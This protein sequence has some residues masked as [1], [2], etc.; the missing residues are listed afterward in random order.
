VHSPL[1]RVL[2]LTLGGT[3]ASV[4]DAK[5][6]H[7]VPRLSPAELMASVPG[8]AEVADVRLESFRQYPSGDLSI[9]D[10]IELAQLVGRRAD[11]VDGFVIT[12]GTDTLE[13]TSY[14]L[15]LLLD[16]NGPPVVVTG[17][18]RNAG[19]PGADGPANILAAI[20]V[21]V[22]REARGLGPLVVFA[23]EIHLPRFVRK[24]H[25]SSVAAFSSPNAG[26]VGWVTE[27]RVRIP[28]LA[29]D[30]G[31]TLQPDAVRVPPPAVGIVK[32]GLGSGPLLPE[33]TAGFEGLVV[34]VF[35]GGHVPSSVVQ[36][37]AEVND[38]IPVVMATRT[39]AGELYRST[40]AFP[41]SEQDLLDRGM[42]SAG[43]LDGAKARL[44][45]VLLL[46][47]GAGRADI[48]ARFAAAP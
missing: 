18:M 33:H 21:A 43:A 13:E 42:I 26:P 34:E 14:A 7:A 15:D 1:P 46:A 22:S 39:G 4:P 45:L 47:S 9:T 17:A 38:R 40:Y 32:L 11:E 44:L 6:H 5:G 23:D 27:E 29:R 8:A 3:I 2:V 24:I 36:S 37:L 41:G 16:E 48:S 10:M 28:L 30:R 25:S 19:L 35:G 31:P 12:Q 20:R